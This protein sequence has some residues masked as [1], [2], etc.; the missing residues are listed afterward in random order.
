MR[1][2]RGGHKEE[3]EGRQGVAMKGDHGRGAHEV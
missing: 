2:E 1:E 3:Y